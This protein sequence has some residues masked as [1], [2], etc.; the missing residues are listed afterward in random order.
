MFGFVHGSL[1][2][3][4]D[5]AAMR[6]ATCGK[7]PC[8]RACTVFQHFPVPPAA[9]LVDAFAQFAA[10]FTVVQASGDGEVHCEK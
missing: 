3:V 8:W 4:C 6:S 10:F 2:M 7:A 5:D 9:A 1:S